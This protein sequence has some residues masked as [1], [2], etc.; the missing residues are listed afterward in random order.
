MRKRKV[1]IL[2]YDYVDILDFS[3]P[4]EVLALTANNKVEQA[5]S[6]Y[7]KELLPTRPFE[8]YTIAE[9]EVEIKTHSGIK[10]KPDYSIDNSPELDILIIPGGPLRA[11][12]SIVKNSKIIDWIIKHENIDYICTVCTGAYILGETGLLDGKNATT[13]HLAL[14]LLKDKYPKIQVLSDIKVV[15][16]GNIISSG[17]VS[18][19]INMA[20]YLVEKIMGRATAERTCKTIEFT[21]H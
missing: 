9:T 20:L 5:L 2:L 3:G 15:H 6:L 7:K 17:G 13:H 10:V 8:V 19:G 21:Y 11:V 16:D 12:Q 18:S 14:K 1:G 4:A